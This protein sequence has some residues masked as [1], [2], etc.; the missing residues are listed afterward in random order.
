MELVPENLHLIQP[1]ELVVFEQCEWCF[2]FDDDEPLVIAYTNENTL[3]ERN[4]L[5]IKLPNNSQSKIEFVD[6]TTGKKFT[7]FA[8]P[9]TIK[10]IHSVN[11]GNR[12]S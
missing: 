7:L 11:E 10:T 3:P 2:K 4:N 6:K 1:E 8:R 12:F 9:K 5:D